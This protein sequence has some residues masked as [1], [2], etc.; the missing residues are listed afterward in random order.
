MWPVSLQLERSGWRPH[1]QG[2]LP[3]CAWS[4]D[5]AAGS[6]GPQHVVLRR[7]GL[8]TVTLLTGHL[9]VARE[10]VRQEEEA[11]SF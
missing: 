10:N 7:D 2:V 11:A 1:F 5:R 8:R 6:A 3:S 4:S 9:G